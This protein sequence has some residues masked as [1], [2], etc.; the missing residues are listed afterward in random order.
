MQTATLKIDAN[1]IQVG[2][3]F[4]QQGY[5]DYVHGNSTG[6]IAIGEKMEFNKKEKG[7]KFSQFHYLKEQLE[8]RLGPTN[9]TYY[10]PNTFYKPKR[11]TQAAR[12]INM[13]YV[14]I[15]FY[16]VGLTKNQVLLQ[17]MLDILPNNNIPM[18]TFIIDSGRGIY[19]QWKINK[20]QGKS[21]KVQ[22][23]WRKIQLFLIEAFQEVGA[24]TA[25]KDI[26]RFLRVPGSINTKTG[27]PV[28]ILEF[29]DVTYELDDLQYEL[30]PNFGEVFPE[31][32]KRPKAKRKK[33]KSKRKSNPSNVAL[34]LN[35]QNLHYTRM[36]DL[37]TLLSLREGDIKEGMRELLLFYY[38]YLAEIIHGEEKALEMV[39]KLH[40]KFNDPLNLS[41]VENATKSTQM[42]ERFKE[43][44]LVEFEGKVKAAGYHYRN[45]TLIKM[46][47]ITEQ[48]QKSLATI[49]SKTEKQRRNTLY[50]AQK[51]S[52]NR[53]EGELTPKQREIKE[54]Q[55]KV[56]QMRDDGFTQR[57]IAGTLGIS[58]ETVKRDIKQLKEND[59]YINSKEEIRM[60]YFLQEG[61]ISLSQEGSKTCQL[62][63]GGYV[64]STE[65]GDALAEVAASIEDLIPG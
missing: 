17:I 55:K 7:R 12:E 36:K 28:K 13:F 34:I 21:K 15:D 41:E 8:N 23:L 22:R 29:H 37:E 59:D 31:Y 62:I 42:V 57:E 35:P 44:E 64:P 2:Q 32:P 40:E 30:L 9:D 54:R 50:Q 60:E 16:K 43:G 61:E 18:P 52:R 10:T 45:E 1:Q 56:R 53:I 24:D 3:G 26:P 14:D 58:V 6:F 63:L 47:S 65:T 39:L 46:F 25:V 49:I 38:R 48:E 51:R 4:T 19:L 27:R 33:I 5:I 11:S 20:A